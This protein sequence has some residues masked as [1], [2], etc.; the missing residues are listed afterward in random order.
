MG[1]SPDLF[2][3][4]KSCKCQTDTTIAENVLAQKE[5]QVYTFEWVQSPFLTLNGN[6]NQMKKI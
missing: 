6:L 4:F 1:T 3:D 2:S 5:F